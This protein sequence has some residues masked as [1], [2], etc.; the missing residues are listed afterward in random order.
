MTSSEQN[1]G[2]SRRAVLAGTLRTGVYAAPVILSLSRVTEGVAAATPPPCTEPVALAQDAVI[3]NAAPNATY[4]VYLQPNGSGPFTQ[5]GTIATDAVG[6]GF[7]L[8]PVSFDSST[9]ASLRLTTTVPGADPATQPAAPS[10]DA[11]LIGFTNCTTRT[12]RMLT[13]A[14]NVPTGAACTA[15]GTITSY[16]V[17]VD[18]AILNA[19]PNTAYDIYAQVNG[20]GAFQK[21]TS[22]TTNAQGNV[23][24]IAAIGFTGAAPSSVVV[25]AVVAGASASPAVFTGTASGATLITNL[26]P[27]A[28]ITAANATS[29]RIVGLR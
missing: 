14:F 16:Q 1:T 4:N 22:G 19:T 5:L 13:R 6:F 12:A 10:F 27:P 29:T 3:Y 17:F 15:G 28:G 24:V 11:P 18:A 23:T 9:V 26:C 25:N 7:K 20:T 8:F 2:L 21:V